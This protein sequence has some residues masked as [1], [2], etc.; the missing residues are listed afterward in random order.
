MFEFLEKSEKSPIIENKN[1]SKEK[2]Y[3][4]H[5]NTLFNKSITKEACEEISQWPG[6]EETP[7]HSLDKL[8]SELKL[9]AIHYK[10][11]SS[12]FGL[13]SFKSLGGAYALLCLLTEEISRRLG[14]EVKA[15]DIREGHY[16][17]ECQEITVVTATDG[18]HGK[19]VAWGAKL[20]GCPCKIY[21]H[22]DVSEGRQ[23]AVEDLGAQVIRVQG[24][25]DESV[26]VA[27]KDALANHWFVV[28]DTSDRSYL[29]IPSHVMAGYTLI[30]HEY[31]KQNKENMPTHVFV[32][33][34]VGGLA[35]ALCASFWQHEK[36]KPTFIVVEP[37]LADCLYQSA[38]NL[39]ATVVNVT[40]ESLMAGL[41]CGKV[42]YIAWE[43]LNKGAQ[44]FMRVAD[45]VVAP[46]M[47]ALANKEY[48]ET[49]IEAGESAVAGLAALIQSCLDEER[50]KQLGL[51]ETSRVLLIGTEGATDP[52][53]YRSLVA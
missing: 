22:K 13:G 12:R 23:Q 34:G 21:M 1:Y 7:L 2:N 46:S 36:E 5:L 45:D 44:Y 8:S 53:I 17:K 19:S 11:E 18:N 32:Q 50:K 16:K 43:I 4:E 10:D 28:S 6:Y 3:P 35:G 49:S 15:S 9:G 47:Q 33:A 31:L 41:S 30:T 42:S 20:F 48:C 25:Y 26:R 52:A 37:T 14:K 24:N 29:K 38:H 51:D 40:E 27:K 39:E